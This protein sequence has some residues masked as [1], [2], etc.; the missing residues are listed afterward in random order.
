MPSWDFTRAAH[1]VTEGAWLLCL[2]LCKDHPEVIHGSSGAEDSLDQMTSLRL[3]SSLVVL[4][5]SL[6]ALPARETQE[7]LTTSNLTC[8]VLA[9]SMPH[10]RD[11]RELVRCRLGQASVRSL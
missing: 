2:D 11:A 5:S 10:A 8:F 4:N 1:L 9:S 3:K 6:A 7:L